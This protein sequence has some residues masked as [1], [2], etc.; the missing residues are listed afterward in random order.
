MHILT[1]CTVQE[2]K[3]PLKN[4]VRQRCA[5]GFNFDIKGLI[6]SLEFQFLQSV[7]ELVQAFVHDMYTSSNFA[8][9]QPTSVEQ[10]SY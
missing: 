7:E 10:Q 5:E 9:G 1:K 3:S 6:P 4:L 8:L 2:E